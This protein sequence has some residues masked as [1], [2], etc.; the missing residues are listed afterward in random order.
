MC[1]LAGFISFSPENNDNLVNTAKVM[2]ESIFSR[3]PDDSGVWTDKNLSI[4]F[5]FRRL[6]ILDL[7][8]AGKQPMQSHSGRY[9][10]CFNGEIY[11]HLDL[12]LML[13]KDK[14]WRG[15]SDTETV[16]EIIEKFG[17]EKALEM[18]VGMFAFSIFDKKEKSLFLARDRMGEKPLYYGWTDKAFIFGS[19]LKALKKYPGFDNAISKKALANFLRYS[20]IPAPK[21]IYQNIYKL[22]PKSAIQMFFVPKRLSP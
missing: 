18:F 8:E 1:G 3:G 17:I 7:S 11:N 6:S 5:S 4:A 10:I 19:E 15:H 12:R 13:S 2:G 9:L 20:Y 16:L 21:S 14:V 22:N